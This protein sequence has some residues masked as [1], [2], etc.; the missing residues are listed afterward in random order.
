MTDRLT[1]TQAHNLLAYLQH[2]ISHMGAGSY[3][4][5]AAGHYLIASICLR[6]DRWV[7]VSV[8][9]VIIYCLNVCLTF[10]RLA[11]A[12]MLMTD[13][14]WFYTCASQST[15]EQCLNRSSFSSL[16]W[17]KQGSRKVHG[18]QW[19]RNNMD[20]LSAIIFV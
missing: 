9:F 1:H 2:N 13:G 4:R 14:T 6:C 3:P 5:N 16:K 7:C 18:F 19:K 11:I 8:R 20:F 10:K 17:T 12:P 15:N